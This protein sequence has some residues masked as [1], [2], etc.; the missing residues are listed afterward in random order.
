MFDFF[1]GWPKPM[2][3]PLPD[4]YVVHLP[5]KEAPR[6]LFGEEKHVRPEDSIT[7]CEQKELTCLTCGA[8]RVTVIR[9]VGTPWQ[10]WREW[11]EKDAVTQSRWPIR[12]AGVAAAGA[13]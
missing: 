4:G 8:V 11:R 3:T 2:T 12:C 1:G 7:G 5:Q 6:H 13:A 9:K 10:E